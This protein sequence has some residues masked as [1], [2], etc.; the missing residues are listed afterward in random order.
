MGAILSLDMTKEAILAKLSYLLGKGLTISKTK[1]LMMTSLKGE[2]TEKDDKYNAFCED[3]ILKDNNKEL[4][5]SYF[6]LNDYS[7]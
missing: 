2:L 5:E 6:S 7:P 4:N 1:I 3:E